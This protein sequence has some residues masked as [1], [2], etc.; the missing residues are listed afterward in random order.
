MTSGERADAA[1][2]QNAQ[3]G[4]GSSR[5]NFLKVLGVTGAGLVAGGAGIA[6]AISGQGGGTPVPAP[7]PSQTLAAS[8]SK[9]IP[10]NAGK[11]GIMF[12]SLRT[13]PFAHPDDIVRQALMEVGKR[14]GIM[15][16]MDDLTV[17]PERLLFDP[18][19]NG[20]PTATDTFGRNPFNPTQ[21]VGT[22][23]FGQFIT[24]DITFDAT[25][26]LGAPANPLL[27]P[28]ER[29]PSLDLD[30]VFGGGPGT[31]RRL[32]ESDGKVKIGT[33]GVYE[34]VPF[35]SKSD[36]SYET[37]APDGRNTQTLTLE[38]LM[39]AYMMAYN[40]VLD[41]LSEI[42]LKPY[43]TARDADLTNLNERH[44]V[45]KEVILWHYHWLIINEYLPQVVGQ[46]VVDDV[47]AN[48]NRYYKPPAGNA[49]MPIEFNSASFKFGHSQAD[50]AYRANFS[51]GT[52]ASADPAKA[53]FY[54]LGFNAA[55]PTTR[56]DNNTFDRDDMLGGYP[57]PRRYLGWQSF[58]DFGDGQVV[59]NR[60]ITPKITSVLFTLPGPAIPGGL[61]TEFS[62]LT[63]RDLLR[64]LTWALPPGQAVAREMGVDALTKADLEEIGSVY[65][66][67]AT[68]TPMWY[69]EMAEAKVA[70]GGLT[71][72]PVGARIV[73][74]TL[75]G[76]MRDDG[77]CYLNQQP[78]FT[79]FLGADLEY[80]PNRVATMGGSHEYTHANFL[81]YAGVVEPGLYR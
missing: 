67:F 7:T 18:A 24:H 28:N 45:A 5:R 47:L 76:I 22:T 43:S 58:F 10:Q 26:V 44:L 27:T 56:F 74:E 38:G 9:G 6:A 80:G 41:D 61:E 69:Y 20:T 39:A 81:Y 29:T 31:S 64:V 66:P 59:H 32:Y 25:S 16:A 2:E 71:L 62:M 50:A 77:R 70:A 12:P 46:A 60:R 52:G 8:A 51:S 65:E 11:F 36:G 19:V 1:P 34:T 55:I 57:A 49:F 40:R 4:A 35:T 42:D 37:L 54:G 48:G 3:S 21:T 73:T 30:A 53:P 79:P 75:I 68:K 33:G 63:Q 23:F 72:G 13:E 17:A 15:D 14:G 78:G